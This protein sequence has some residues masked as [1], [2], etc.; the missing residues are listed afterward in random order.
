M[1]LSKL[2]A[3]QGN[4]I[5][6]NLP[7]NL[8]LEI[9]KIRTEEKNQRQEAKVNPIA[10][11]ERL[12]RDFLRIAENPNTQLGIVVFEPDVRDYAYPI[13]LIHDLE[14]LC[15]IYSH[16][17]F[18]VWTATYMSPKSFKDIFLFKQE[19]IKRP[20][21][22]YF[23]IEGSHA[24]C[25]GAYTKKQ[26][27]VCSCHE[28]PAKFTGTVETYDVYYERV[29][30]RLMEIHDKYKSHDYWNCN[31]CGKKFVSAPY[32][33]DGYDLCRNCTFCKCK[34]CTCECG[35][36]EIPKGGRLYKRTT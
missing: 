28:L 34:D 18:K 4:K 35:L 36:C 32:I 8:R 21:T 23:C 29:K 10:R 19:D 22:T 13:D 15:R 9:S 3:K 27:C 1:K 31:S 33:I 12:E 5:D 6:K 7:Y 17:N 16:L 30:K 14:D 11:F 25:N 20:N 24:K 2:L 26:R